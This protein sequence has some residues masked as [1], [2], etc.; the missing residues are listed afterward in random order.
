MVRWR[1]AGRMCA[2]AGC[3]R[4]R[5]CVCIAG[6]RASPRPARSMT[7]RRSAMRCTASCAWEE[8]A[9]LDLIE[10]WGPTDRSHRKL[11]HRGSYTGHG[12]RL[13][14]D[15]VAGRAQAPRRVA[16][17][18]VPPTTAKARVSRDFLGR[19]PDLDLGRV[20]LHPLQAGRYAIVDVVTRYWIGYLL[21]TEQTH[22][23]R[24]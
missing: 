12:V 24:L 17:R 18:A 4:S 11:A 15:A 22:T 1:P 8:Q 20:A 23:Q 6:E 7:A 3:S 10:Q 19:E 5:M 16:R 14:L 9:I 2:P 21:T 13:A